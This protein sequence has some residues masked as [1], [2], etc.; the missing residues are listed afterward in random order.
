MTFLLPPS[1]RR[2]RRSLLEAQID[3]CLQ[4]GVTLRRL[5]GKGGEKGY[6]SRS[7]GPLQ[8]YY[9]VSLPYAGTSIELQAVLY[10]EQVGEIGDEDVDEDE[11]RQEGDNEVRTSRPVSW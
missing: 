4:K 3:Y 11:E 10:A 2:R 6:T 7:S 1:R 9:H 5:D 8:E